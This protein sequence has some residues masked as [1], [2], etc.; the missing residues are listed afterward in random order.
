MVAQGY[1]RNDRSKKSSISLPDKGLLR[2]FTSECHYSL[3]T[4][5]LGIVASDLKLALSAETSLRA[6][7]AKEAA[8]VSTSSLEGILRTYSVDGF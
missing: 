6:S 2:R 1:V 7:M 8:E 5:I 4:R 3:S